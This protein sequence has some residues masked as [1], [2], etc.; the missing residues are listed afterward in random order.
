MAS[1][2][3]QPIAHSYPHASI[4]ESGFQFSKPPP[5]SD[6]SIFGCAARFSLSAMDVPASMN[7]R[8]FQAPPAVGQP[9][10][11]ACAAELS[12]DGE[13]FNSDDDDAVDDD[14]PSVRRI[15]AS[16]RPAI[17]VVDLTGDD[18][19]DSEGDDG[20]HTEVSC[21]RYTRTARH[22]VTL[23]STPLDRPLPGHRPTPF[24]PHRPL[25]QTHW[26]TPPTT[27]QRHLQRPHLARRNTLGS[28]S[29]GGPHCT[30]NFSS[31]PTSLLMTRA[32]MRC[33]PARTALDLP[34]PSSSLRRRTLRLS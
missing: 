1:T 28:M 17:E 12:E 33:T 32:L 2:C 21:L 3:S 4:V 29:L 22:R 30:A 23:T 13:I 6:A 19:G 25:C 16:P 11:P 18:D 24:P 10:P 27:S 15:L 20:N 34:R 26:H 9:L 8:R 7:G 31:V 5:S 14:L